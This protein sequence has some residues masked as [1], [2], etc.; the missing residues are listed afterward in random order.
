MVSIPVQW[1]PFAHN[2]VFGRLHGLMEPEVSSGASEI[3][4]AH[5]SLRASAET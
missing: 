3:L 2:G 1:S 5:G 4:C